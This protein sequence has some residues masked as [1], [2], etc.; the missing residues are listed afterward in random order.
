MDRGGS[1]TNQIRIHRRVI[2]EFE[3]EL[4]ELSILKLEPNSCKNR[5]LESSSNSLEN[6]IKIKFEFEVEVKLKLLEFE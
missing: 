5:V 2:F 6:Q 3:Y 1:E 4:D